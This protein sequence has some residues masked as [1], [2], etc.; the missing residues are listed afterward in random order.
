[1]KIGAPPVEGKANAELVKFLSGLLKVGVSRISIEKG[2]NSRNKL[3]EVQGIS[4]GEM[5]S[6]LSE[7]QSKSG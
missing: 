3:I 1:M 5:L 2:L 4:E 7:A 6:R